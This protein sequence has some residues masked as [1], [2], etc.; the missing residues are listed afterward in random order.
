MIM[1]LLALVDTFVLTLFSTQI[2]N[3]G[4]PDAYDETHNPAALDPYTCPWHC[5][6]VLMCRLWLPAEF[7]CLH[8]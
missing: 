8:P 1:L 7:W 3:G 4:S 5:R 2:V 6:K